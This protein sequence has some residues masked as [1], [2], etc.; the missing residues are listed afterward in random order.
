MREA[1][2]AMAVTVAAGAREEVETATAAVRRVLRCRSALRAA[3]VVADVVASE[4]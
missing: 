4:Q 2:A 3:V 1:A